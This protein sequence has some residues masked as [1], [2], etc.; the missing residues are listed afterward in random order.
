MPAERRP[1]EVTL[2]EPARRLYRARARSLS[3][4]AATLSLIALTI[5]GCGATNSTGAASVS[6]SGSAASSAH[7]AS[8]PASPSSS[9]APSDSPSP[10]PI[11]LPS[12]STVEGGRIWDALPPGFPLPAG[13]VPSE[14]GVAASGVFDLAEDVATASGVMQGALEAGGFRTAGVSGPLEDGGVVIDSIGPGDGCR[15]Q[16]TIVRQGG[17]TMMTVLYGAECPFR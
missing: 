3:T 5:L 11:R 4:L 17:V 14:I 7:P 16:T 15:A 8:P 12:Q 10:T 2:S 13:A 6:P 1:N 9:P